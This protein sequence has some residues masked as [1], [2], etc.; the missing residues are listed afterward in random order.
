MAG[1]S[2]KEFYFN[3]VQL[4]ARSLASLKPSPWEKVNHLM[5]MCPQE[6]AQGIY[7]FDQRGQDAV[8]S[9]GIYF[10]Q[11]GCQ[12]Q[13]AIVPY[14]MKLLRGLAKAIWVDEARIHDTDRIPV[15][16]R[17]AFCINTLLSDIACLCEDIRDEI[18]AAQVDLLGTLANLCRN[19]KE[20]E[21]TFAAKITLCKSV[22]PVLIGTARAMGRGSKSGPPFFLRL[23]P[24]PSATTPTSPDSPKSSLYGFP[25]NCSKQRT[26]HNFR[27][28][29]HR[30]M[31]AVSRN[32]SSTALTSQDSGA[33]LNS[34]VSSSGF[35]SKR[36]SLYSQSSLTYDPT[37]YYFYKFGSSFGK[38]PA[39]GMMNDEEHPLLF[40]VAHLQVVL[41]MAKKLLTTDMLSF[42]DCQANEVY[43][44]GQLKIFPYKS[45][46][47]TLNLVLVCLLRELLQPQTNLPPPFTKDVQEFVKGLFLSGQTELQTRQH[48]ASE[49]EDKESNFTVVNRFKV[50]V[51]TNAACVDLLVWAIADDIGADSLCMR[52]QEKIH[53]SHSAK[54]ALAHM[55]LLMVCLEGLGQLA[56]KFP[57]IS[58]TCIDALRDFLVNPSPILLRLNKQS[59]H[60][61]RTANLNIMVTS[62]AP[63]TVYA[64][65]T[66]SSGTAFENLRDTAIENLCREST[67]VSTNTIVALGHVA[68]ALKS[69][70]RTMESIL[71]FFQQR[72]C[73]P[74]SRLDSLIV[75]QLGC[76]VIAKGD[77]HVHEEVMKM[78][79]MITVESSSAYN[80]GSVDS[81][82]QG[83]RHVS[84]SVINALANIA[85]DLEG[86]AEQNELLVRLL[87][88][89]VQLGLEGKR[90]SERAPAAFKASSSAGNL[91][92]L[93]PVI[94]VL[95]RRLPPISSPKP[96]LLKLSRDFWLYCVVMGFTSETGLWPQEW[97][98][99]LKEIAA[100]SPLLVSREHLRSELQYNSA[101]RSDTVSVA[102]LQELRNQILA[103]L[104]HQAD[105]TPLINKLNF[106]Q[107]TYLLSVYHLETLRVRHVQE[108][109]PFHCM[110]QY[111]EDTTIQ[112]DKAGMWQCILAVSDKVF[113]T[114]LE[115]MSA[116]S[117]NEHRDDELE[118]HATF[119]LVKFNHPQ[120]QIRRV[121]D[122]HLSMLV[123]R[124]P[125]LLWSGRVLWTML[126]ILHILSLSL[127]WDSNEDNP[128][129]TVPR[130]S[131]KLTLTDTLEIRENIV[132]DFAAR[133]Q[134]IL[135]EAVKWAPTVTRSHLVGY[136]SVCQH[137]NEGL[138]HH[139][140]LAMAV[141]SVL[142]FSGPNAVSAPLSNTTL[143]KWPPCVKNNYSES[144]ASLH[145]RC[146]FAGQIV[147]L[148]SAGD[149]STEF[150]EGITNKLLSDLAKTWENKDSE[151]HDKCL[152]RVCALL[153]AT[154]EIDRR[155]LHALCWSPVELFTDE[156]M[157]CAI[158][159][160]QWLL[161]D[162]SDMELQFLQE[163]SA[164]WQ[165]TI[166]RQIGLFA[167]DPE[168]VDPL[169]A[170]EGCELKPNGPFIGPHS[171]WVKFLSERLEV[172]KYCNMNEVEIFANILHHSLPVT[173][174]RQ[175]YNHRHIASMSTRFRLLSCGLSLLQGDI[176][177]RTVCKNVLRERIYTAALDHFCAPPMCPTQK[178]PEL[179]DDITILIKFW[180]NLYT[181]KK[182]LK[183]SMM[184]DL[185]DGSGSQNLSLSLSSD[186]RSSTDLS[187][188]R[189]P[190]TGWMNTMPLSSNM[191]TISRRSSGG[192]SGRRENHSD[193]FIKGYVK[194]RNLILGLLAVDIEFLITWNN[195]MS[196]QENSF[197]EED[198]ISSWKSQQISE[199]T[200]RETA[201][202]S[203][204]ISPALAVYLPCRFTNSEVLV[205][206][207]S[208]LVQCNPASV[209]Y[210]PEALQYLTTSESII[211]DS[212]EL[213][214]VLTWARVPPIK[215]L[216]YFSRQFPR[217]PLTAQYAVRVL[218]SF[219]PDV[220]LFY[221]PQLVQ[222]VRHDSM[223]YVTEFIKSACKHSQLLAHQLIWNM[224]TNMYLDEEAVQQ[225]PVMFEPLENIM[226]HI[227]GS[228]SGP[229]KLFY[230]REFD[231]FG[232][233]TAISG[234]IRPYPKGPQRKQACLDAL[235]KI[236]VQPGC[237]LPSNPEAVVLDID[238][239]SGTPM[240]SAAKAPYLARFKV[241]HCG[242]HEMENKVMSI[243]KEEDENSKKESGKEYWQAAIFKVGDDVRQDMLA[244]QVIALFQNIFK[245][246]GLDLFLF[247]YRVV[248]TS[249]GCGVI[250]CVPNAKSRDQLG[251]QTDIGLY[252]YFIKHYGD[253]NSKAFQTA[254]RNFVKSMAAYSVI[255]FLLQIKDRHNGNI[256]VDTDG[257][258]IH[259]DFGFMFESSP[260]G[261][262]GFEPDIKLTD[263]MVMIM[264]GKMEAQPFRWFMELCVQA[265]LAVRPYREAVIS[266]VTLMLDTGLPCFR[267]QT[268]KQLRARFAPNASEKEAAAFMLK[269]IR[270]SC[271]NFRTRTYDMI[272]YYQNQ[273]PY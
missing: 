89:F 132:N 7:K 72:F 174:G 234:E 54:I 196:L 67:L 180:N 169:A 66:T 70:P 238:F 262:L 140:G 259:I 151:S 19:F 216:A 128:E 233:V 198:M 8:F 38:L 170:H 81:R 162:R 115:V 208:R 20:K 123:D 213:T 130:T 201:R 86:E 232:K 179:R 9:L 100:K 272:Q 56:E 94:S 261:N 185:S 146:H 209:S 17:F 59:D 42:L 164:A 1:V 60:H 126:D 149:G 150:V 87:E 51:Q 155:L 268:V 74:P 65:T 145:I 214:H 247:P 96:R 226:N 135:Q 39:L 254:R 83:Y 241:R 52:L 187:Q 147:G 194:K 245:Q 228:L 156:A 104:D 251:R 182:Y 192:R 41:A 230:E 218:S 195:P 137:A 260:G 223:G 181:D 139:S 144:V 118:E 24:A 200:W 102:E 91:G 64:A 263:E 78:F 240:Q 177:P 225:D 212:S 53:S 110:I 133:S 3:A 33:D 105:V 11:S 207:I 75:D 88:L 246:V 152:N 82:K 188:T 2:N 166:D 18:I 215:A 148:L 69:T 129:L 4:L 163:M 217:H 116:K 153:I 27:P 273:I 120:K 29:L 161:A 256:M 186:L 111:L 5:S 219:P 222:A 224:K 28:I 122:R 109:T 175:N 73:Q 80:V 160:W 101:I 98:E 6:S 23:F 37:S 184:G 189:A 206:E 108:K 199:K 103:L 30:S 176:L 154:K 48:D 141:E 68:V 270:D 204:E 95:L 191:S 143:D 244:L 253:E 99:Q 47:E 15:S 125:H 264:G 16:E 250:E 197:P 171:L 211:N 90:A 172:A 13:D 229:A 10:L 239:K 231:F 202:L 121:A 221:I 158:S 167:E 237:Y 210:I 157:R 193:S 131:H 266:L 40:T 242:I 50:N 93:I 92:V 26:F 76:M 63:T 58:H 46:S 183:A 113:Q 258:I 255:G 173:V 168:Q 107:C 31:S 205:A 124:F 203:W 267:G 235:A 62:D 138:K 249:P 43:S 248:A 117:R 178:G 257:H 114:Y 85:A 236:K 112:K 136:L 119:L 243:G 45:F 71:Q 55:P 22:V 269:I 227:I 34:F 21:S 32:A 35:S 44:S 84:L 14:F 12:Y 252:E 142:N 190:P 106:A 265:F 271:L 220:I 61:V 49:R 57:S 127:K 36:A 165:M 134:G 77:L 79:T 159:C 97:F 25:P